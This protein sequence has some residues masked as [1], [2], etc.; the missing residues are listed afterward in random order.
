[1]NTEN[2]EFKANDTSSDAARSAPSERE[3]PR[4]PSR[5]APKAEAMPKRSLRDELEAQF[6]SV[7]K[8][9][10]SE[11]FA[12]PP[13]AAP[14]DINAA[15]PKATAAPID[16]NAPAAT[17]APTTP[18]APTL[19]APPGWSQEAKS[20]FDRASPA[21]QAAVAKREQEIDNGFRVLQ[22]YKGLEEFTP[23]VRQAGTTHADVMRRAVS[24]EKALASDP[25]NTVKYVAQ[26]AGVDLRALVN[27]QPQPQRQQGNQQAAQQQQQPIDIDSKIDQF[28]RKRET[29]TQV[30]TFL[31]DPAN[32]HA[33]DVLDDMV[34][35]IKTGRFPNLKDAY[36]AACYAR[37]EIREQL[38]NKRFASQPVAQ[39]TSNAADQARRA[40]R[41]ITGS[42]APGASKAPAQNQETLST[43][44]HL[45]R[46]WNATQA[47]A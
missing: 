45:L 22:D 37:P 9:G 21:I 36:E 5:D 24:W 31:D 41:S 20:E 44:E 19:K 2:E 29:T 15:P 12:K 10:K 40:S 33:Q 42:S 39:Q 26:V 6:T 4:E 14:V 34:V 27:G 1:M 18:T 38:I 17:A 16:P 11:K 46:A 30:Q 35:L 3:A 28:M 7:E 8:T 13:A 47:R 32:I 25:I 43:R 23:L